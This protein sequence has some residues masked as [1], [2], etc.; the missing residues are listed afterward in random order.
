MKTALI[1]FAKNEDYYIE[2]WIK[3]HTKLG[4]DDIFVY[5]HDWRYRGVKRVYPNVTWFDFD[6]PEIGIM[7]QTEAFKNFLVCQNKNQ[8]DFAAFFDVD[9]FLT[10]KN[11]TLHDFLSKYADYVGVGINWR[12]FG[13]NNAHFNGSYSLVNRFTAC[14]KQLNKH[15]KLILNLKKIYSLS[16]ISFDTP[17]ALAEAKTKDIII[18]TDKTS[19]IHGPFNEVVSNDPQVYLNHYYCKTEEEY[20]DI[21]QA[22]AK[23][24]QNYGGIDAFN[25]HNVNEITDTTAKNFY[26]S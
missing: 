25:E 8:Y 15:V 17:H 10:L 1:T 24:Y 6:F 3:Y 26:N 12:L 7:C 9:E 11:M 13:N 4:F 18:N 23:E 2:E 21:K 5:Q 19:F 16:D 14:Q 22:R 20:F